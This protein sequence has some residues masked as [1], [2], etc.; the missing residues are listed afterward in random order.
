MLAWNAASRQAC[1]PGLSCQHSYEI[2][3]SLFISGTHQLCVS[4]VRW[5]EQNTLPQC[6]QSPAI[7]RAAD[8]HCVGLAV[9][10]GL[11]SVPSAFFASA[12]GA[13][14]ML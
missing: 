5:A 3:Q 14:G 1:M 6:V 12:A 11:A 8:G 7:L 9:M 10:V 4:G 13:T 2:E